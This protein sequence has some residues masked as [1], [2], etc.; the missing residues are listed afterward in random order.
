MKLSKSFEDYLETVYIL[1]KNKKEARVKDVAKALNVK[2]PSV[3]EAIKKLD[4][5]GFIKYE[6]YSLVKLTKKGE[7]YA[8]SIYKKH[9][10]L[11]KFLTKIL[12]IEE[13]IAIQEACKMEHFLSDI[14]LKKIGVFTN[15]NIK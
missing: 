14:T 2:L 4:N 13:N 8:E 6:R 10:T 9:K 12:K 15:K 5:L 1:K 7:I 3:T 11:F